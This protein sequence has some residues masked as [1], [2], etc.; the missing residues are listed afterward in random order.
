M[1]IVFEEALKK[2]LS[3]G[4]LL[5]VYILFGDDGYLK[6]NYADKIGKM[7]ASPDDI[8]N[9]CSFGAESDLQV[10]YD[11]VMQLPLMGDKKYVELVDYDFENCGSSELEKLCLILSEAPDSAVFLLRFD[12]VEVDSKKSSKFK[13]IVTAAEKS[14]GA[15]VRLDHRK[16]PELIKMLVSGASKRGCSMEQSAA[17]YLVETAGEDINLLHNELEKLCAFA[18]GQIIT[19]DTVDNVSVKTAE[20]SIYNLSKHILSC[21]TAG[22]L[23]CLDELLF[24]KLEPIS[25]LYS[26]SSAYVDVFRAYV[27]KE[28]GVGIKEVSEKF[29]YKSREFLLERAW[30]AV[31]KFDMKKLTL[32]LAALTAADKSLKS[33]GGDSRTVLEQLIIRLI[34]INVKGESV[35]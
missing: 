22:A 32:S 3:K 10:I 25:I 8:F 28:Q 33:F 2:N 26:V 30:T 7:I 35:D 1:A 31:R 14:G 5:P 34:Y 19:K 17:K 16:L 23:L 24:M 6:K 20:A 13:K 4:E 15:A 29:G 11:A 9:Y 12:S 27:A 21:D 18:N